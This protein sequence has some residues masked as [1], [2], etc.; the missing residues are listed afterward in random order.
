MRVGK[1]HYITS[2]RINLPVAPETVRPLH[3]RATMHIHNERILLV[4]VKAMWFDYKHMNIFVVS[5]FDP[6]FFRGPKIHFVC[7]RTVKSGHL[8]DRLWGC[9]KS[10]Q[11]NRL[12]N[13][14]RC[15]KYCSLVRA[16]H[17][18]SNGFTLQNSWNIARSQFNTTQ[19]RTTFFMN[20]KVNWFGISRP[21]WIFNPVV[22]GFCQNTLF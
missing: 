16:D 9:I 18:L 1:S 6:N 11:F 2:T 14:C 15:K 7:N 3:L 17:I 21:A 12:A 5:A 20:C 13:G 4:R 22:Y 8:F 19:R 10:I